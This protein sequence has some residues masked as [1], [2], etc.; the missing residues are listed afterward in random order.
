MVCGKRPASSRESPVS[1]KHENLLLTLSRYDDKAAFDH[2]I[3]TEGFKELGAAI[4]KEG[5][6]ASD[7]AKPLD[8]K[9][10]EKVEGFLS[11]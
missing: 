9:F 8:I 10:V 2:H 1:G 4:Q 6:M 7:V 3:A 5:L 11:R